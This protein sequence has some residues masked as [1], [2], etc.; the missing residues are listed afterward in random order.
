[1]KKT[2]FTEDQILFALKQGD[3][4]QRWRMSVGRS[5]SARRRTTSGGSGIRTWG[6]WRFGSARTRTEKSARKS[7]VGVT[8]F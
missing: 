7:M 5:G 2:K 1:M 6:S 8:G 3:A 4:G